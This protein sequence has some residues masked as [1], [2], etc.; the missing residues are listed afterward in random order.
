MGEMPDDPASVAIA[1][2]A[3]IDPGV[4]LLPDIPVA[5][6]DDDLL[7][8][9]RVARRLAE[10]A[11]A[12]PLAAPRVIGLVGGNGSGK[13]S[14]IHMTAALLVERGDV[15]FVLLD[16]AGYAGAQPLVNGLLAQLQSIFAAEGVIDTSDAVRDTLARYGGVVADVARIAGVK[17]DLGGALARSADDVRA[18]IAEMTQEVGKRIVLLVDHVDR[19]P[20]RELVSALVALRH[21]A[22]IPYV[23]IVLAYDRRA[24]ALRPDD[25]VDPHAFERL[26]QAEL[27]LPLPDR[28]LLARVIAGGLARVAARTGRDLDD[29]LPLFDPDGDG[30]IAL[31][32]LETPR[33]AKRAVNTLAAALPLAEAGADVRD[34]ALDLVLRLIVPELDGTRLDGRH[35]ATDAARARLLD[36]L[37][38]EVTFHRRSGAARTALRVLFGVGGA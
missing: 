20:G 24:A 1:P 29:A 21:I 4:E 18:E 14:V 28:V 10:L 25:E 19:L 32:L 7:G 23:T 11:C 16:G 22:A 8:R 13:S 30:G 31:D 26:V 34:V 3:G 17:V 12:L 2:A 9:A 38:A 33:D 5:H 36:E 6:P 37:E 27:P 35:R 15:G